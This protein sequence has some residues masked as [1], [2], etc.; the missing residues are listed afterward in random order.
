[1]EYK[2]QICSASVNGIGEMGDHDL[3]QLENF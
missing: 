2:G 1:M 3:K